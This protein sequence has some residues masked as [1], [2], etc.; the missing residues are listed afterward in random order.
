MES[1][2]KA[3]TVQGDV[4]KADDVTRLFAES[5]KAFGKLDVLVNNAGV[6][7]FVPVTEVTEAEF[8]RQFNT[9]VWGCCRRPARPAPSQ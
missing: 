2:G 6:F 1:G 5:T 4:S 8:H 3:I 7:K 9:N